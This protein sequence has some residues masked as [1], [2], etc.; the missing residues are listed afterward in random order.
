[1][2]FGKLICRIESVP[3]NLHFFAQ[4]QICRFTNVLVLKNKIDIPQMY[5]RSQDVV[6]TELACHNLA[7]RS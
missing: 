1:M 2:F 6:C 7:A 3:L 4:K 5:G